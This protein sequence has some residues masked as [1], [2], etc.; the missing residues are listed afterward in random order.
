M[1]ET[2]TPSS[3][4][5]GRPAVLRL[6]T[7][8]VSVGVACLIGEVALRMGGYG[9]S[10]LNPFH[11]FHE[12]DDLI[13]IRG[14]D[15][16]TG[17]LKNAEMN[18][19]IVN[20]DFGFRKPALEVPASPAR[21]NIF[22]L[23]DSFIWGWGVG[24]GRVVTDRL[25]ELLPD[26]RVKNLGVSA[27]GTVQQF[28]IFEKF[29]LPVLRRGDTVVLAFFANDFGDNVGANHEGCLYAKVENGNIRLIPP[30]GTACPH[31]FVSRV[32]DASYL[33]NLVAYAANRMLYSWRNSGRVVPPESQAVADA[34]RPPN[35]SP[36]AGRD[37]AASR[38]DALPGLA[39]GLLSDETPEVQVAKQYLHGFDVECRKRA[40]ELV[41]VYVPYRPEFGDTDDCGPVII[42]S[43]VQT[44]ERRALLRCT[45][46][47][48][49]PMIDLVP[50]FVSAKVTEH[51]G[52]LSFVNDFHWNETGH[53]VAARAICDYL[54]TRA[55]H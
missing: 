29:V 55:V 23:G 12:S 21:R 48:A 53:R 18:A 47:L 28:A 10:Y 3:A 44:A 7:L 19:L 31:G 2:I 1:S 41:V 9:R 24:Q 35:R 51:A 27:T 26:C 22:V 52:R 5:A 6:L 30:D 33:A 4:L 16:F 42:S 54:T 34:Q 43:A 49:I 32:T 8:V 11:A 46:A 50:I 15:N 36:N 45:K 39:A 37:Q 20:D 25:Q 13:G 38:N 40:A 17:R 14:R